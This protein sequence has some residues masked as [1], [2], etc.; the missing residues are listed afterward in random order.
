MRKC[1]SFLHLYINGKVSISYYYDLN[2]LLLAAL[3][4]YCKEMTSETQSLNGHSSLDFI[5]LPLFLLN[6][7][8]FFVC[9][10]FVFWA[11]PRVPKSCGRSW[12]RDRTHAAVATCTA[13]E[14]I[15]DP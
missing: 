3:S 4:F 2:T 13:A 6:L 1:L 5:V 7:F 10:F 12:A 11:P 14:A 9:L 15:L 8:F